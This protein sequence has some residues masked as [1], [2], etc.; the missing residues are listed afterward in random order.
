MRLA[1]AALAAAAL[2]A[3][4]L[5]AALLTACG[6][7]A[8]RPEA[9]TPPSDPIPPEIAARP[10]LLD[11]TT[12]E[13]QALRATHPTVATTAR[14]HFTIA[15]RD[16]TG[17]WDL[18]ESLLGYSVLP[19]LHQLRTEAF[20]TPFDPVADVTEATPA[21]AGYHFA[22]D[23]A[24][25][26]FR[27]GLHL[28]RVTA[29]APPPLPPRPARLVVLVDGTTALDPATLA[30][31]LA[32]HPAA[33]LIAAE[34]TPA[35]STPSPRP[36]RP[37]RRL[38]RRARRRRARPGDRLVVITA[39]HYAPLPLAAPRC[40]VTTVIGVIDPD[41]YD[42]LAA[43]P[44]ACIAVPPTPSA[45]RASKRPPPRPP[46]RRRAPRHPPR[47][48]PRHPRRRRRRAAPRSTTPAS[49]S[50]STR[51][52]RPLAPHR[53]RRSRH[54]PRRRARPRRARRA[55]HGAT[56]RHG[57][58][59]T[60]LVEIELTGAPGPLGEATLRGVDCQGAPVALSAPITPAATARPS[61]APL[62]LAAAVAEKLA[63]NP[64]ARHLTWP[65]LHQR[66][67]SL[68]PSPLGRELARL[69]DLI[70]L[71]ERASAPRQPAAPEAPPVLAP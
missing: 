52:R 37:P 32:P 49:P 14:A 26:P 4:A 3:A 30:A 12:P 60:A 69:I 38:A 21:G 46:P 48:P 17:A 40:A 55:P 18:T 2:T 15:P 61:L 7:V 11:P 6:G 62:A 27:P 5:T 19:G 66:A 41:P 25:S 68:P 71:T 10:I 31:A 64:H 28:L 35:R 58:G 54:L 44:E 8:P 24:P 56:L 16:D 36:H 29:L 23:L 42:L 45:T 53:P 59:A 51:P 9:P 65:A 57:A 70:T 67:E 1:A 50:A 20:V 33:T 63:H 34:E 13:A 47:P 39:G 43:D 22:A